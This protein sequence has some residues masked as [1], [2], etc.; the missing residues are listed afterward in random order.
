M[1]SIQGLNAFDVVGVRKDGGIDLVIS[2]HGPLDHS[3]V[4]L[5]RLVQKIENYVREVANAI[6]PTFFERYNVSPET[7]VRIVVSCKFPVS[8]EAVRAVEEMQLYVRSA[9]GGTLVLET[10][11]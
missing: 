11:P 7:T 3:E 8:V 5:G 4:T 1:D 9:I 10:E 6:E 2:C